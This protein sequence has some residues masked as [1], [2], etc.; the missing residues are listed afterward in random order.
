VLG[1]RAAC[2][3]RARGRDP[4]GWHAGCARPPPPH[5]PPHHHHT[6]A[7]THTLSTTPRPHTPLPL[8]L[9][10]H[11]HTRTH[12]HIHTHTHTHA[13]APQRA[14]GVW[15]QAVAAAGVHAR[16]RGCWQV[17]RL[18]AHGED[19]E[20]VGA[21]DACRWPHCVWRVCAA[22]RAPLPWPS[23]TAAQQLLSQRLRQL[24]PRCVCPLHSLALTHT[25]AH[26]PLNTRAHT[27]PD[28]HAHPRARHRRAQ[29]FSDPSRA[30]AMRGARTLEI[31]PAHPLI[32]ALRDKVRWRRACVGAC[33]CASVYARAR[34]CRLVWLRG[35]A[36]TKDKKSTEKS[37][38]GGA[39]V[40]GW[41]LAPCPL[42]SSPPP[43]HPPTHH[44]LPSPAHCR[45]C[46]PR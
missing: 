38:L 40:C 46:C 21:C 14:A 17:G 29:A 30:A 1:V 8:A 37:V 45:S 16:R 12:A 27:F 9:R 15:R 44:T 34:W 33:V 24:L 26:T 11:A 42:C 31:N 19:H 10:T 3:G 5:P 6:Q 35:R 28:T 39:A 43:P 13:R 7:H 36:H 22:L 23:V 25:H 2:R 20:G 4:R 41:R 18:G 32:V